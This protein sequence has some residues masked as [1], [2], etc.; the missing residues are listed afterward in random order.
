MALMVL[1]VIGETWRVSL[2]LSRAYLATVGPTSEI[3]N[4]MLPVGKNWW[5]H[6]RA[7]NCEKIVTGTSLSAD[8]NLGES[9]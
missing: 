3:A 2:L 1:W 7:P 8:I 6:G 5:N 9:I 4:R